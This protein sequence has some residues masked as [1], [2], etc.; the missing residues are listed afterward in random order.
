MQRL[1]ALL[2]G[3]QCAQYMFQSPVSLSDATNLTTG[4]P[5]TTATAAPA[6]Q[7]QTK[8]Q[9]MDDVLEIL[10]RNGGL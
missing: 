10:I 2:T 7:E 8:C 6:Q 5:C 9:A 1:A 4:S 3:P